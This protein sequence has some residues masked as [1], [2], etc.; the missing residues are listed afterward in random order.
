MA[1]QSNSPVLFTSDGRVFIAEKGVGCGKTYA[2]HSCMKVTG[3]QKSFGEASPFYCPDPTHSGRFIEVATVQGEESRWSTGLTGPKPY[4]VS[5]S[6]AR[7]AN[8]VG[9]EFD[10]QIHYGRCFD[11]SRF[12]QFAMAIVV[13]GARI[14]DYSTEDLVALN[15]S[16]AAPINETVTVSARAVYE[17]FTPLLFEVGQTQSGDGVIPSITYCQTDG[18]GCLDCDEGCNPGCEDYY[19]LVVPHITNPGGGPVY[20][21]HTHDGGVSWST[22]E[23]PCSADGEAP[24]E[25]YEIICAGSSLIVAMNEV[26]G[27]GS[28]FII[29]SSHVINNISI[30][31]PITALGF[32]VY[33]LFYAQGNIWAVGS[34]GAVALIGASSMVSLIIENGSVFSSD[35][36]AVHGIDSDNMIFGGADGQFAY[37]RRGSPLQNSPVET[38]EGTVTETFTAVWM[39]TATE[40][41]AG[42]SAG[43]L[44]CTS[45]CGLTW[46][47]S[48]VFPGCI[49]SIRFPTRNVGYVAIG[50]PASIY[51]SIDGGTSWSLVEDS[52]GQIPDDAVLFDIAVCPDDPNLFVAAGRVPPSPLGSPCVVTGGTTQ[53]D[54]AG[55]LLASRV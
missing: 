22:Y 19:A 46:H 42:T 38:E 25:S 3:L 28:I 20:I 1:G 51:R 31:T 18:T 53:S 14:S 47:R 24:L 35:W 41:Y 17:V 40:W 13:E 43:N 33:D 39:K 48:A 12:D 29:P 16:E 54:D 30:G 27:V 55:V 32:N 4:G 26:A 37:R 5:S 36:Y 7:I 6:L 21:A 50:S 2:Y 11:P 49:K 45:N 44:Y 8:R 34:G 10:F 9:C 23:I 15:P 52:Q